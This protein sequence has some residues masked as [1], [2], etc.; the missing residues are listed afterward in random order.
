MTQ[1]ER[2]I[3]EALFE[4]HGIRVSYRAVE[5]LH[6]EVSAHQDLVIFKHPLLGI[7]L[8][9]DG[10]VNITNADNFIYHEMM[11]HVPVFIHGSA[12]RILII[13]GG[14]GGIAT[15]V[16][17]HASV[18]RVVEVE[19]DPIVIGRAVKYFP[20]LME[21]NLNPKF[22]L[23]I[24]DG[25]KFVA[26]TEEKFDIII[27]DST[28]PQGPGAV[29]FTREFYANCR[30][31]LH[32]NGILVTQNGVPF[33]QPNELANSI[34]SFRELFKIGRCY[35]AAIPTYFGGHMAMGFATDNENWGLTVEEIEK[36]YRKA[37]SFETRYWTP[38]VHCAAFALPR[39]IDDIVRKA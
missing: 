17:K 6:E 32:A 23:L 13:G 9:I 26:E 16:L 4:Q 2:W 29:L 20:Q 27:V 7:V 34:R 22:E 36:R 24:E 37:G 3:S 31:C 39:F 21:S 14:D 18:Q 12:T 38:E 25:A 15:E 30:H 33:L 8:I 5:V 28:D 10:A 35:I 19:I 1:T 11:V